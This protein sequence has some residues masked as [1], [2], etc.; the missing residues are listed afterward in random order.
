MQRYHIVTLVFIAVLSTAYGQSK[1]NE[2][3]EFAKQ[4]NPGLKSSYTEFEISLQKVQQVNAIDDPRLQVSSFGQM[5]ETRTGQQMARFSLEQ[6]LPWFG[7]RTVMKDAA[8]LKAEASF[9]AFKNES[10]KLE[11]SV[12][13]AYYS[14]YEVDQAIRLNEENQKILESMKTL[15]LS[16]FRNGTGTMS[17]VL[18][19][20]LMIND[21]VTERA[22][23]LEKKKPLTV[24]FN[25]LLHRDDESMVEISEH[26]EIPA[27]IISSR[28]SI[29]NHPRLEVL[30]KNV[31]AAQALESAAMKQGSPKL[32]VGVEYIITQKRPG[33]DF[34]DNGK[35]AYMAMFSVSLPI[36]RNKYKSAIKETQLM[37]SSYSQ[38]LVQEEN[39]LVA[40]FET[41]DFEMKRSW[42]QT[43]LYSKQTMQTK[44]IIELLLSSYSNNEADFDEILKMN[45]QLLNYQLME[46]ESLVR[47]HLALAKI[48]YLI[49][50]E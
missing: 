9:E 27:S 26:L 24:T 32:G 11:L 46:V 36:Y 19:T 4:N 34:P 35:D 47:Y 45:Q 39:N 21:L 33:I 31:L 2:Y 43:Q 28:D 15:A 40:E 17:D 13:E 23:L 14:L 6:M 22:I 20:D 7:T 16:K 8:S 5:V 1:L 42:H 50:T 41:A 44:Q 12:K 48:N 25:R 29:S 38:M 49:E 30:R 3:L 18:R 10:N 37:Q